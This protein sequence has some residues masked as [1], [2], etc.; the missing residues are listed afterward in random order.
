MLVILDTGIL[1]AGAVYIVFFRNRM[2]KELGLRRAW[3]R[4]RELFRRLFGG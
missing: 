2:Y 3:D 4:K 1:V